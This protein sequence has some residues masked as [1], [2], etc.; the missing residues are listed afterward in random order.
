VI[1]L[2]TLFCYLIY[3]RCRLQTVHNLNCTPTTL[4]VQSYI[5]GYANKRRLNTT[6]LERLR[7]ITYIRKVGALAGVRTENLQNTRLQALGRGFA[8]DVRTGRWAWPSLCNCYALWL[9][10]QTVSLAMVLSISSHKPV[11]EGEDTRRSGI[12]RGQCPALPWQHGRL[13]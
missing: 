1:L 4:G 3:F 12:A 10:C 13:L 11:P 8:F 6:G 5:W 7:K 9:C 2:N